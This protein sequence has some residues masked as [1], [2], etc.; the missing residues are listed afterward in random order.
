M[1]YILILISLMTP[2]VVIE[3]R[4][5]FTKQLGGIFQYIGTAVVA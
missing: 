4:G 3:T 1:D 5:A 2:E